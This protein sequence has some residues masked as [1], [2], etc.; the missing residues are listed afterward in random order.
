V[1]ETGLAV[2]EVPAVIGTQVDEDKYP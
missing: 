2:V 1:V